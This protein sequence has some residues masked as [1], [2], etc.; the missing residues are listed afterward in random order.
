[1]KTDT[2]A[3]DADVRL[4]FD[5][6]GLGGQKVGLGV[7]ENPT[8]QLIERISRSRIFQDY[9]QA[10]SKVTGL[11]L[12]LQCVDIWEVPHRGKKHQNPFCSLMAEHSRSC[13]ACLSA[14]EQLT[15]NLGQNA[16]TA[17]CFAGMRDTA[18]PVTLG[19]NR[20]GFLLTGQ[21]R[22]RRPTRGQFNRVTRQLLEW[23]LKVDLS[24]LEEAY[25]HTRVVT[26]QQYEAFTRQTIHQ[27]TPIRRFVPDRRG[28]SGKYQHLLFLQN[29]QEG[30]GAAFY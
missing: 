13:A 7:P 20:I 28:T 6:C 22:V 15:K 30:N 17:T 11:P 27:G 21:I 4:D 16:V 12:S 18:V 25:F 23:G 10:F 19:A 26:R 3:V 1:V 8:K 9:E 5:S 2:A 24:K 14:H 29:I